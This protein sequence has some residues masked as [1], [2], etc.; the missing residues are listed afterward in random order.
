MK[1]L[2]LASN[3]GQVPS[4]GGGGKTW[5]RKTTHHTNNR[6]AIHRKARQWKRNKKESCTTFILPHG[7]ITPKEQKDPDRNNGHGGGWKNWANAFPR[8]DATRWKR[9][10]V[11]K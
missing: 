2:L 11:E 7:K 6:T 10:L 3:N 1:L 4:G 9:G 8:L 5:P